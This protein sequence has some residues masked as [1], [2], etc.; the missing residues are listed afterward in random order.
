MGFAMASARFSNALRK[1]QSLGAWQTN[2][3]VVELIALLGFFTVFLIEAGRLACMLKE[4][5]G[6]DTDL[7]KRPLDNPRKKMRDRSRQGYPP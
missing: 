6:S 7:V 2:Y 4:C 1:V 3:P 5:D